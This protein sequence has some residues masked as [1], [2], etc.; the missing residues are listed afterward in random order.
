MAGSKKPTPRRRGSNPIDY[1]DL[2][3]EELM[4][5]AQ[6]AHRI[7]WE[8]LFKFTCR[9]CGTRCAFDDFNTL[10]SEGT[11]SSCGFSTTVVRGGFA[12]FACLP[13]QAMIVW[14]MSPDAIRF[15]RVAGSPDR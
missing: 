2:P 1:G 7:G 12:L 3:R 4:R 9:A 15:K 10:P 11:C 6:I 8:V 14:A 13:T 5:R